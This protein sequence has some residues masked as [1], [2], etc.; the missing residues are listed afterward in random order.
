MKAVRAWLLL[1]IALVCAGTA[2]AQCTP[3]A[4]VGF[5]IP[6]LHSTN[7]GGCMNGDMALLDSL[8]G[9]N[10]NLTVGSTTPFISGFNN[11]TTA[12]TVSTTITN[13]T[14]GF[15]GQ[16]V[17]IICGV[18]DTFTGIASSANMALASP[19]S[20]SNSTAITLTL[21]GTT[22]REV[23]RGSIN[24][25]GAIAGNS[26]N[27]N[28]GFVMT[29]STTET[30][31]LFTW[32]C[33]ANGILSGTS[34]LTLTDPSSPVSISFFG[35]STNPF[36]GQD[37]TPI[38][39]KIPV[40]NSGDTDRLLAINNGGPGSS[41]AAGLRMDGDGDDVGDGG[42]F[43]VL[44]GSCALAITAQ[45]TRIFG[46]MRITDNQIPA[47]TDLLI[48]SNQGGCPTCAKTGGAGIAD[49]RDAIHG[50]QFFWAPDNESA[51]NTPQFPLGLTSA[52]INQPAAKTFA[53][54]CAM[55]TST[56]CTATVASTYVTPLC[57]AQDVSGLIFAH[58]TQSSTTVTVTAAS[59]N[60]DTFNFVVVGNPN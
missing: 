27:P 13:L 7:W 12:N 57:F 29:P 24:T 43:L 10:G 54:T 35:K 42:G 59:S 15:P 33:F 56:T 5:Q 32:N 45:E 38:L 37:H 60:S 22:W 3:S 47:A 44:D 40:L 51:T 9:G 4:S 41:C 39:I 20:C 11:W 21:I 36:G 46:S 25:W 48:N 19:W 26:T 23:G 31:P 55:A 18:G 6:I 14:G 1:L 17:R 28:Q 52:R 34:C 8:L 30:L 2:S 16:T 58:C 49:F 50:T 53:G